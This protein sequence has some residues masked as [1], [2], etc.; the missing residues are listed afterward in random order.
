MRGRTRR[1]VARLADAADRLSGSSPV[2]SDAPDEAFREVYRRG[3]GLYVAA[4][5]WTPA[6][7]AAVASGFG[8]AVVRFRRPACCEP[9][10]STW[11]RPTVHEPGRR[12]R[13]PATMARFAVLLLKGSA[14]N[15]S[16][17]SPGSGP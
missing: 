10:A 7:G 13:C 11:G 6:W 15:A 16:V 4:E 3:C 8:A 5:S 2:L 14:L 9:T 17:T 1:S 12:K